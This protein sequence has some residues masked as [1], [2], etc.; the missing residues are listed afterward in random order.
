MAESYTLEA[1]PRTLIG[2]KVGQLR[3][4]GI[5]PVVVYG[6]KVQP[7]HLQ[8]NERVLTTTLY[9]AGGTHIINLDV[10]GK[11]QQVIA[12]D[13]QRDVMRGNILHVDFL[14]IDATTLISAE[15][16]VHF[17]GESPAVDAGQGIL[18]N[19]IS[20][21]TIE[22]LPAD[23]IDRVEVDLAALKDVND[24]IHVRDLNLGD[25]VRVITDED[26]MI[27]RVITTA[28]Q[29]AAAAAEEEL[30]STTSAEPEVIEKGKKDEDFED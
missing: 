11:T 25:K 4:D 1:Q 30:A 20:S 6:A 12:R 2:K 22:A 24:S 14:A 13:V 23:L 8:I 15:I 29:E 10:E 18:M 5:V 3:R 7:M 21:V 17:V 26:A 28:A 9:K 16:P 19:G 27:V